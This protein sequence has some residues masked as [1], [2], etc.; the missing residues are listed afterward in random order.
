[1]HKG[2]GGTESKANCKLLLKRKQRVRIGTIYSGWL[3]TKTGVPQG[4]VLGPLFF[5]IF[6]NDFIYIIEQSEACSF[7]DDNTIF[8]VRILLKLLLQ[9]LTKIC[10]DHC[11]GLKQIK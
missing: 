6:I 11:L 9:V 5:N 7:A 8:L 1:M 2:F 10:L 4:S 3:K